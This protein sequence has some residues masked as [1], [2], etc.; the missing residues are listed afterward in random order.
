MAKRL[1]DAY[2]KSV[3]LALKCLC[4]PNR[5]RCDFQIKPLQDKRKG[6]YGPRRTTEKEKGSLS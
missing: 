3:L 5:E 2:T 6:A 4:H 1:I